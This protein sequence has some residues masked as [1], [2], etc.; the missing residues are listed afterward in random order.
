MKLTT[1]LRRTEMCQN[2]YAWRLNV[3]S[4]GL[5]LGIEFEEEK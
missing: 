4:V 1:I 3:E 5:S 2:N